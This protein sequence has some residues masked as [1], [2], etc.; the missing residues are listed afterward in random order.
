MHTSAGGACGRD[1]GDVPGLCACHSLRIIK[2]KETR[3]HVN[4]L[5]LLFLD[6]WSKSTVRQFGV[7]GSNREQHRVGYISA[8]R[9]PSVLPTNTLFP[10]TAGE[11]RTAPTDISF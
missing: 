1:D 6:S 9:L 7:A 3:S 8:Y 4:E 2:V 5:F 10:A 11:E